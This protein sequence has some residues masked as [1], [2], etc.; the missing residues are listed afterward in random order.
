MTKKQIYEALYFGQKAKWF[1]VRFF[2][3]FRNKIFLKR[4]SYE[5]RLNLSDRYLK[6]KW[7][8]LK[9]VWFLST[10]RAGTALLNELLNISPYLRVFHE[11]S[12]TMFNFS[13]DY[14]NRKIAFD[15][16]LKIFGY[17]RDEFVHDANYNYQVYVET[18]NR[19]IYIA[20]LI[21]N[22]LQSSRFVHVYRNPY[23]VIRSGMRRGWY[24]D[25]NCD[26]YRMKPL[27]TEKYHDVWNEM[28]QI[29]KNAWH[30]MKINELSL[31]VKDTLHVDDF[32]SLPVEDLYS[33]NYDLIFKL[34]EFMS[35]GYIPSKGA[36]NRILSKKVNSQEKGFFPYAK[37]W[38]KKDLN[39]V[40]LIIGDVATL[41]SYEV[42]G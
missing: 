23:D 41:L 20:D 29:E 34:Y 16:A 12:P 32:F 38:E 17:L 30:W 25:N 22:H 35:D 18:N 33:G 39:K 13:S 36:V 27:L 26:Y 15:E 8:D 11:P 2:S 7:D 24:K 4:D 31:K 9:S 3:R 40:N 14:Y 1:P 6:N 42:I 28:S 21:K 37:E 5:G 19:S 10:G